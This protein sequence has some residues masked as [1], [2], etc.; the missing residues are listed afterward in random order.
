MGE[1]LGLDLFFSSGTFVHFHFDTCAR[2]LCDTSGIETQRSS[3]YLD[4]RSRAESCTTKQ[5]RQS[6][7]SPMEQCSSR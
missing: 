2:R 3:P 1:A 7:L 5:Y 4:S 6:P